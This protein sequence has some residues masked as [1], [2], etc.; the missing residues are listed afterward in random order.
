M[1]PTRTPSI[2][3]RAETVSDAVVHIAGVLAAL[4]AAPVLV[5]LAA[6]QI[7]DPRTVTAIAVYGICLVAMLACSA[8][9]HLAPAPQWKGFLRRI[10]QSVIYLKIAGTY[11]PF[12]V[13][14]GTSAGLFLT[15]LWG[16]ALASA[17]LIIFGPAGLKWGSLVLYLAIG[18]V[19]FAAGWPL[20][21]TMSPAGFAL[22]AA[23][24]GLYTFGVTFFLW[25]RLPFHT[26]IWH[27]AVLMASAI[28]YA[29]VL[30]ELRHSASALPAAVIGTMS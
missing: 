3:S 15:G 25:E 18:W 19:G 12:A 16:A 17:A 29:A 4:I 27:V 21:A 2:Y 30:V 20:F 7:G 13:L 28:L 11:T 1:F 23:G 26:T 22:I 9:Y 10:D 14:S 24:G 8:V 6:L 5:T